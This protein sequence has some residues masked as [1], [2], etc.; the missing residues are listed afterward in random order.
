VLFR[1]GIA[2]LAS[3]RRQ[4]LAAPFES[5]VSGLNGRA[6]PALQDSPDDLLQVRLIQ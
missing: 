2:L 1:V 3:G 5:L 6:L 4:L